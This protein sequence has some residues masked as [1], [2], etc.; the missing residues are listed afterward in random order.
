MLKIFMKITKISFKKPD[1]P[2]F[3]E[4]FTTFTLKKSNKKRDKLEAEYDKTLP[5]CKTKRFDE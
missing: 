5:S 3:K 2:I 4:G 1:D